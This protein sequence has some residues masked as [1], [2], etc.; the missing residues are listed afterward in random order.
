MHSG[1]IWLVA[2]GYPRLHGLYS[3][4]LAAPG[5]TSVGGQVFF[6]ILV[7]MSHESFGHSVHRW[8]GVS[9]FIA[10]AGIQKG[11]AIRL[12]AHTELW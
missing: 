10:A 12:S 2:R 6:G 8:S 3:A 5:D 4:D 1:H 11:T 7:P 9:P